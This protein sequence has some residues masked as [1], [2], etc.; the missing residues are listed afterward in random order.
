MSRLTYFLILICL[1]PL[2]GKSTSFTRRVADRFESRVQL[3]IA[4]LEGNANW[5]CG[6]KCNLQQQL[7][8]VLKETRSR[9]K[10]GNSPILEEVDYFSYTSKT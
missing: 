8:E 4:Y 3:S 2:F 5:E 10:H 1:S 9:E 6:W 7:L